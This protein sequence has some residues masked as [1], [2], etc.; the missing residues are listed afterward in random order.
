MLYWRIAIVPTDSGVDFDQVRRVAD[1]IQRQVTE[2]FAPWWGIDGTI[3]ARRQV[4]DVPD[5]CCIIS[6]IRVANNRT[7]SGSKTY[8]SLFASSHPFFSASVVGNQLQDFDRYS[9][10]S[11]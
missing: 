4:E 10:R 1:A 5:D 3:A 9:Y 8:V 7:E 11:A 2:D 6:K